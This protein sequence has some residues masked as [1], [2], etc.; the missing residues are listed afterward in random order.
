MSEREQ[1]GRRSLAYSRWHRTESIAR[2]I[3]MR[4]AFDLAMLDFDSVE[5]CRHC[6]DVV[7]LVELAE[8]LWQTGKVATVTQHAAQRLHVPCYIV[9]YAASGDA[10]VV[11]IRARQVAPRVGQWVDMTPQAWAEHLVKLH[12]E[13]ICLGR[14][15]SPA[16]DPAI[17]RR[18]DGAL[19][20]RFER[21]EE[22]A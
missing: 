19:L 15:P 8:G 17:V 18:N 7:A 9:L 21:D 13:H 12:R 5:Y 3:G 20:V 1:S 2:Y 16:T 10:E 11:A 6:M 22:T 14:E 4:D